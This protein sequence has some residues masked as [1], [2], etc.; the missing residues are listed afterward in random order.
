MRPFTW[1][2]LL[3]WQLVSAIL[4]LAGRF[5]AMLVGMVLIVAGAA[6]TVTL[7]GAIVG[8]PL[9]AT[10]VQLIRHGLS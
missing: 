4:L 5:V 9:I 8:L 1:P 3:L 10:G 7:I 2:F 6:L